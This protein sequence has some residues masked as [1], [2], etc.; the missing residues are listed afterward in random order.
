MATVSGNNTLTLHN[1]GTI[2]ITAFVV[3]DDYYDAASPVQQQLTV[4]KAS[5]L[6]T[7][8]N[9]SRLYGDNNPVFTIVYSG[10]KNTDNQNS[11]SQAPTASCEATQA[12][13]VGNYPIMLSGGESQNY[14]FAFTNGTLTIIKAPLTITAQ[15]ATRPQGQPNPAFTFSYS[16]FKNNETDLV[17]DALPVATCSADE[18]STA[19]SYVIILSG[20]NDKNYTYTLV[21]GTLEVT[22]STDIENV[23]ANKVSVYPNPVKNELFIQSESPVKKVEIYSLA[24]TLLKLEDNFNEKISVSSLVKGVYLIKIYTDKGLFISKIAKE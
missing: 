14:D 22:A 4:N 9:K 5:L 10:F 17:L 2:T 18:N 12:S 8:D 3:G 1:A 24:G 15:N 13:A 21:N 19:G 20:G 11:L 16:G 23:S 6:V 7:T